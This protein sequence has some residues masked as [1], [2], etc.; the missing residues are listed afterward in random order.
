AYLRHLTRPYSLTT[1]NYQFCLA[2]LP[3][4]CPG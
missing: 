1:G 3:G 2:S 4:Q